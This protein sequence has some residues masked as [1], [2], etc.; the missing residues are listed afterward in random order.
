MSEKLNQLEKSKRAERVRID[1]CLIAQGLCESRTQARGLILA[2]KIRLDNVV[3]DKPGKPIP[4][5]SRLTV[6]ASPR[7]VSRGGLKLEAFLNYYRL[8]VKGYHVLDIGASTG[9]FTD[10]LLQHGAHTATCVDVG[11][12]QLHA[13]LRTDPRVTNLE[14]INVRYLE[15]KRLPRLHYDLIVV[16]LSFIS[17][18]KVLPAIW[19]FLKPHRLLIT[20][21]KPQFEAEKAEVNQGRGIIR[22]PAIQQRTLAAIR[23]FA[24]ET[25]PACTLY[26]GI[27]S[28]VKG[29]NGNQEFFLCTIKRGQTQKGSVS[30]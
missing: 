10:C 17:L 8:S 12:G 22:A 26:G 28:P 14:K 13:K 16:D 5:D 29:A 25:L 30:V 7:F 9:G 3:I 4:I 19:P 1:E 24:C 15:A 21:V 6:T 23:T 11:Y 18:I 27:P 2:G 20:L